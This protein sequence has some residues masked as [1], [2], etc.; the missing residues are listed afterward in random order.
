MNRIIH[1]DA[2]MADANI[3]PSRRV[4]R[5]RRAVQIALGVTLALALGG[6]LLNAVNKMRETHAR[7]HV[8]G[9]LKWLTITMHTYA[10]NTGSLPGPNAPFLDPAGSGRAHPVSWRV[11]IL[12][13]I[14]QQ[15]IYRRYRFDEPWD[16]PNN[17]RLVQRMPKT[18][19]HPKADSEN[20]PAGHTHYRILA[21]RP[22]AKPSA[23]FTDGMPG[24][25]V[26]EIPDGSGKTVLIVEA[27]EAV[28]WTMPE[29]LFYDRNQPLPKLGGFF[30][31]TF[32]AALAD[33]SVRS[34][35]TDMPE[36]QVRARI[37]KD[38]GEQL[39]DY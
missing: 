31:N 37:T 22:D 30:G 14:E 24:P 16:G 26:S 11:L 15:E 32:Q 3:G 20:V 2:P 36:D 13:N 28:P 10:D 6:W 7:M 38:G 33:G 35:R 23:L 4:E 21:S 19:R 9:N 29:M 27:A 34:F 8:Y 12:P 1:G 25:K 17:I 18:F 5:I 39:D